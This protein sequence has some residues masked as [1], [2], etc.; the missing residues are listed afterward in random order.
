LETRKG[1]GYAVR[2]LM[3][4]ISADVYVMVDG[5][6]TYDLTHLPQALSQFVSNQYDLMTGNRMQY[7]ALGTSAFRSGHRAGNKFF[8]FM[9]K[10][11]FGAQSNDAFSGL[12]IMSY[13][14]VKSFP[15]ISSEFEIETELTVYAA[16]MGLP[17]GEFPTFVKERQGSE[18][19]L[20]SMRDGLKILLFTARLLHREFPLRLYAVASLVLLGMGITT[21]IPIYNQYLVTGIVLRLPSLVFGLSLLVLSAL[22]IVAGL[23]LKEI[24]NLKYEARYLA[25]L[26]AQ[27][28]P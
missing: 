8:S 19:K 12:R 22:A 25:Y 16:R 20:N 9:F 11:L 17:S 10:T 7:N 18:S 27:C 1:K 3:R 6:N 23:V 13:R 24:S 26:S 21:I 2:T 15:A 4:D 28:P 14:L 5:D